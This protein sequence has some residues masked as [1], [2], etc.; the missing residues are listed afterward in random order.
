MW[1]PRNTPI[2]ADLSLLSSL[3]VEKNRGIYR[4]LCSIMGRWGTPNCSIYRRFRRWVRLLLKYTILL[5]FGSGLVR[6][7]VCVNRSKRANRVKVNGTSAIV[8]IFRPGHSAIVRLSSRVR[9]S[10]QQ[11]YSTAELYTSN[12][13]SFNFLSHSYPG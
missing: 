5:T 1:Q 11:P 10:E 9:P 8:G 7:N 2:I 6:I 13:F 12:T 3:G 4:V